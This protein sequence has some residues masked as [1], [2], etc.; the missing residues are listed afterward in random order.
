MTLQDF[1]YSYY[2]SGLA[3]RERYCMLLR[4]ADDERI[5]KLCARQ[6]VRRP[7]RARTE[8]LW[9]RLGFLR[10]PRRKIF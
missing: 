6:P 2:V 4:E 3:A 7:K 1:H 8:G 9:A 5:G 10:S